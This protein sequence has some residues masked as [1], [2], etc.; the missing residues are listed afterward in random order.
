[1]YRKRTIKVFSVQAFARALI[2]EHHHIYLLYNKAKS[3]STG[4]TISH[5]TTTTA[6][7]TTTDR[8]ISSAVVDTTAGTTQR[9]R[10]YL[11]FSCPLAS[12]IHSFTQPASQE[13][14]SRPTNSAGL[15]LSMYL[16]V[17][18]LLTVCGVGGANCESS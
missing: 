3:D 5:T 2:S 12:S 16:Y 7:T 8:R 6:T 15:R 17:Q 14:V 9:N 10:F 1:M 13:S 4:L 18:V 11:Q